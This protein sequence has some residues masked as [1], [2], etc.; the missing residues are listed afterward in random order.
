MSQNQTHLGEPIAAEVGAVEGL[1]AGDNAVSEAV[2]EPAVVLAVDVALGGEPSD[3]AAEP[4]RELGRIK[5]VDG[6][7]AALAS[8]QLLIE[9]IDVVAEH[10]RE[11]HARNHH[12]LLGVLLALRGGDFRGHG[13]GDGE[14]DPLGG[15]AFGGIGGFAEWVQRRGAEGG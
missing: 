3:L 14:G 10:G 13:G 2:V 7:D 15:A 11:A 8:Q 9:N 4:G 5:T 6:A 12:A 1:L